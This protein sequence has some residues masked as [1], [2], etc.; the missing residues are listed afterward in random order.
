[1]PGIRT[2]ARLLGL[3]IRKVFVKPRE[4]V[5]SARLALWVVL[6]SVL[7]RATTLP[8]AQR[9]S[10]VRVGP[11]AGGDRDRIAEH[12]ARTLDALLALDFFVFRPICWKRAMVL[13]R[14][15]AL[16]GIESRINFGLQ[17]RADGTL[18]GH[19]WL[20]RDGHP[21]LEKTAGTYVVT[22]SLPRPADRAAL[23]RL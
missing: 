22:F 5:L 15:L 4:A 10:S 7:A 3:A 20:E 8:R 23:S 14:F 18:D 1:M 11:D 16:N 17:K 13:H 6:V 2:S 19:A 12:L 9:I 21:F